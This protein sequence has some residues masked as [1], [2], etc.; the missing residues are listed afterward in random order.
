[1]SKSSFRQAI[2]DVVEYVN[3]YELSDHAKKLIIHYFNE[4]KAN[5]SRQKAIDAIQKY[6]QDKL[7]SAS[8]TPPRLNSLLETMMDEADEWDNQ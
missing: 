2:Y 3:H 4:S 8:D 5:S 7:P 6:L 1:M